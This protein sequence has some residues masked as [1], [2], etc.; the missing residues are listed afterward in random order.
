MERRSEVGDLIHTFRCPD[1]KCDGTAIP[2]EKDG[3]FFIHPK[4]EWC[5]IAIPTDFLIHRC[6]K[7][8]KDWLDK[9]NQV[10]VGEFLDT[11]F[12]EHA[13]LIQAIVDD[14]RARFALQKH[15]PKSKPE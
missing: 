4:H 15:A 1:E 3:R 9:P 12:Q 6:D 10:K 5:Y 2:I 8:Q 13:E 14:A 7:C 11:S